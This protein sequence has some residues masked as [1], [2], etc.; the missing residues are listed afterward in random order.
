MRRTAASRARSK[1]RS[2]TSPTAA[3][4]PR[5]AASSSCCRA[6]PRRRRARARRDRG[7]PRPAPRCP[8]SSLL[9]HL[10]MPAH[11]DVRAS[12]VRRR[13]GC[14]ATS[15]R[16]PIAA[17]QDFAELLH[18]PGVGART[19]RALA[20][21]RRS[22]ARRALPL[23]RSGA[24]LVR[25]WRQG[26]ASLPG[27]VRSR[28][29][30]RV[31]KS[32]VAKA[33]LGQDEELAR[34]QAARRRGAPAGGRADRAVSC[35]TLIAEERRALAWLRRPQRVRLGAA[36]GPVSAR[37]EAE[38]SVQSRI[39]SPELPDFRRAGVR[40]LRMAGPCVPTAEGGAPLSGR[41][42]RT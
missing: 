16:P 11:H 38:T 22:R 29:D 30:D 18:V 33:K 7:E 23:H 31:M 26:P 21:G 36:A 4:T 19:V 3:R 42:G 28:R 15:P 34:A 10:V 1:A 32:A 13:R 5:A 12:D 41:W 8:S 35:R 25:P 6:R 39:G 24:L 40:S 20:H 14:T 37:P 2:S 9:P 27:A 17:R